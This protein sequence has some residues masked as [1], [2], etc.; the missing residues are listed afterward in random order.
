MNETNRDRA[1]ELF[2][3]A[4]GLPPQQQVKFVEKHC[5][6][7]L[8]L[9]NHVKQLLKWDAAAGVNFLGRQTASVG[10][11][12]VLE[13]GHKGE[14]NTAD[15]PGG[16][17]QFE[18]TIP[19]FK[20]IR[21][22]HRGGQGVV[23]QA[24]QKSTKRIVAVKLLLGSLKAS[25]QARK[26]F[27]REIE[28]LAQLN[29]PHIVPIFDSGRTSLDQQYYVM[30]Y[31]AGKHLTDYVRSN[32][33]G[34]R[35]ALS[36]VTKVWEAVQFAHQRGIIHRDLK[37]SNILVDER[38]DPK[39]LDFGLARWL[40][41]P[42]ETIIS[43]D[44]QLLGTLPY[45]S[46]EQVRAGTPI[47]DTRSDVYSLGVILY[48]IL[49]GSYPYPMDGPAMA[50]LKHIAETPPTPLSSSWQ[51]DRGI[52][53]ASSGNILKERCPIDG[54][55]ETVVLRA[56]AKEPHRRYQSAGEFA[57]DLT[58]YLNGDPLE[59]KRDSIVYL[60][61]KSAR[62]H[63]G[64]ILGVCALLI[65]LAGWGWHRQ[66]QRALAH[67]E[68]CKSLIKAEFYVAAMKECNAALDISADLFDGLKYK[69]HLLHRIY[70]AK[71]FA[72]RETG[73]HEE[74][75]ELID[76]ALQLEPQD[77]SLLNLNCSV[78]RGL[79]ELEE[80]ERNC[81]QALQLEQDH[82]YTTY[83]NLGKTL[84]L[85]GRFDQ[86]AEAF[87]RAIAIVS[88][89][90]EGQSRDNIW[91]AFGTLQLLQGEVDE[92]RH[93]QDEAL[94]IEFGDPRTR[95]MKARLHLMFSEHR[96]VALAL[97]E[98]I[99]AN[100]L[101]SLEDPRYKRILARA[102]FL[103]GNY[104]EAAQYAEG[105][106]K[107]GDRKAY[108]LFIQASAQ[109]ELGNAQQAEALYEEARENWPEEFVARD[110]V[111]TADRGFL[112]FDTLKELEELREDAE[113]RINKL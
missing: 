68:D 62:R 72:G 92:A 30:D 4:L 109:A 26:R 38:G 13:R 84:V 17:A 99:S 6:S 112:W 35:D 86:A 8:H 14:F 103:N 46:P 36:L 100:A 31:V 57:R 66:E 55:L 12:A 113:Q 85:Q 1:D 111:I 21:E 80:A 77:A 9:L 53:R 104:E 39:L 91:R 15:S 16:I 110:I 2:E 48:E 90:D 71:K 47:T 20:F 58:R 101:S 74:A 45:I 65:A 7:D 95:L 19:E 79:G 83:S 51:P 43:S 28:I 52:S 33:L 23:Y 105:A 87:Q 22:L 5:G 18:D 93:S 97:N 96:D 82:P 11:E 102:Y 70:L 50:A 29:H 94:K 49:T 78:L 44:Q 67:A 89:L 54:E 98:A 25:K 60:M 61:R 107:G 69:A 32:R 34:L 75:R 42:V 81:R 59:A 3:R 76:R 88:Q 106:T 56:L 24:I 64:K 10:V 73:L 108:G 27:E 37:P 63:W 40:S 41:A